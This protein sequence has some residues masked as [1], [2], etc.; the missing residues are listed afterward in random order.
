MAQAV[1]A[2]TS[3]GRIRS[4]WPRCGARS[5][6]WRCRAGERRLHARFDPWRR[7]GGERS[8]PPAFISTTCRR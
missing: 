3:G 8:P 1:D 7:F 4:P 5:W 2:R 6:F